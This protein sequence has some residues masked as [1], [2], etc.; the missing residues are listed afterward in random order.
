MQPFWLSATLTVSG[1][2]S[3]GR[4]PAWMSGDAFVSAEENGDPAAAPDLFRWL[5]REVRELMPREVPVLEKPPTALEFSRDFVA[6]NRP[7]VVRGAVD[8]WPARELW[9]APYLSA[10]LGD[11][12]VSVN[13]TPTGLGDA[14]L[15]TEGTDLRFRGGEDAKAR[16]SARETSSASSPA[17]PP[18]VFVQPEA[19]RMRF[20]E[21]MKLVSQDIASRENRHAGTG[22]TVRTSRAPREIAYVSAQDDSFSAE[23]ASALSADLR[24]AAASGIDWARDAFGCAP[25]AVNLWCGPRDAVTSFHRDHYENVYV[26]L[27][28]CKTFTLLPPCDAWRMESR[29]APS[30][31]FEYR[32]S[33]IAPGSR[34]DDMDVVSRVNT[35]ADENDENTENDGT[36]TSVCQKSC[37][38]VVETPMANVSWPSATPSSVRRDGGPPAFV[39]TLS[40]GETLYLPA[41]WY[42]HVEQGRCPNEAE[43]DADDDSRQY[44][45]AVNFWHD[46]RFDDRFAT[47]R[48]LETA[49]RERGVFGGTRETYLK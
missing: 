22:D 21:F 28:G 44:T 39:V 49:A 13:V 8:H 19:R 7:C 24:G 32:G 6:A 30:A 14:L 12:P 9:T 41:M 10:A 18:L 34:S 27:A 3:R 40:A 42:H 25:D 4:P 26:V 46:M 16:G 11:T 29:D 45:I 38:V 36:R 2:D 35:A 1:R 43:N 15:S 48:F 20:S 23:F 17:R 47:A 5:S 37:R 33:S 31:R